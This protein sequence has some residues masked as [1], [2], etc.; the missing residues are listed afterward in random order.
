MTSWMIKVQNCG[1]IYGRTGE[2]YRVKI[3][4]YVIYPLRSA[5]TVDISAWFQTRNIKCY[6]ISARIISTAD[7]MYVCTC[8]TTLTT[9]TALAIEHTVKPVKQIRVWKLHPAKRARG[10]RS[11]KVMKSVY[12][13]YWSKNL[14][15]D[16]A[17]QTLM[18][19]T[20]VSFV[21]WLYE[22]FK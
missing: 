2:D 16:V 22:V 10:Q 20:K 13:D 19:L 18:W 5:S 12:G 3:C 1:P 15:M 6:H 7:D 17:A 11:H 14:L 9:N 21:Q 4:L 8:Y